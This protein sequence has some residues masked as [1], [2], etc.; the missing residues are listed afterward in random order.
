MTFEPIKRLPLSVE[1][2]DEI[3]KAISNCQY[4]CGDKLPSERELTEQFGVSR[5]TVRDALTTLQTNGL[6]TIKKGKNAGA[7]VIRPTAD[8]IIENFQNLIR[9]GMIDFS[10]LIDARRY[11]EPRAAQ[12]AAQS[13]TKEDIA[14]IERL[15]DFA[16]QHLSISWRKA[17]LINVSFHSEIAKLTN[18]K[19]IIYITESIT[20]AFSFAIIDKTEHLL[21][22]NTIYNFISEHRA[23]LEKIKNK[24]PEGAFTASNQHLLCTLQTYSSFISQNND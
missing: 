21:N 22:R 8:P 20:Q 13:H 17:R 18:N 14:S 3:K 9:Y 11:I 16:E 6:I 23:I 7:Y 19:L 15:L 1:I 5:T 10:H 2:A 4:S 12:A 24:D